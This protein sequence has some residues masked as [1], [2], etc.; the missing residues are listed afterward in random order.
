MCRFNLIMI[1][2]KSAVSLMQKENYNKRY[3][4][5]IGFMAFQKGYCNCDSFVGSLCD[6]KELEYKDAIEKSKNEKLEKLYKIRELVKK[7]GYKEE[8][9]K[10]KQHHMELLEHLEVFTEH[11]AEY[12]IVQRNELE[13]KYSGDEFFENMDKLHQKVEDMHKEV[14]LKTEYQTKQAS[15]HKFLQDN[16]IMN[17]STGYFLTQEE[18]ES[19]FDHGIPLSE[20]LD[21]ETFGFEDEKIVEVTKESHVIDEV[22]ANEEKNTYTENIIEFMYYRQLFSNL[23][24]QMNSLMFATI[25][26]E[27]KEIKKIKTV[28]IKLLKIDDLAFL[29]Y[30]EMICI[31][32]CEI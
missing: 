1:R 28:D 14:E 3:D 16:E 2:D 18:E 27:P 13:Q 8:R 20:I 4:D 12:E 25:W 22:I 29:N 32:A 26:C 24:E 7:P 15:Y 10:F 11:I 9:E 6:K 30:N 5:L 19:M 23:V 21:L 31:T 17:D